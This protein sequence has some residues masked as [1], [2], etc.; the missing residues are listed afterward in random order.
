MGPYVVDFVCH[1]ARL[2][3]EVDGYYHRTPAGQAR[4]AERDAWLTARGY[5]I[6]RIDEKDARE[7]LIEIVDR[8]V[9][10]TTTPNPYP[11]PLKGEGG[12]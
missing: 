12:V 1:A 7:R 2:V 6:L 3:I 10:E 5:R 11:S 9:A 8:I 4:D